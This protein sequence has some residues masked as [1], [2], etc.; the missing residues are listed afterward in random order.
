MNIREMIFILFS[1][2]RII[3]ETLANMYVLA[4]LTCYMIDGTDTIITT[5]GTNTY[6]DNKVDL[7]FTVFDSYG[8]LELDE[9]NKRIVNNSGRTRTFAFDGIS[10]ISLPSTPNMF[11]WYALF[12]NGSVKQDQTI[13]F[14]KLIGVDGAALLGVDS[15]VTLNDGDYVEI[16]CKTD[17]LD[18]SFTAAHTQIRFIEIPSLGVPV[19]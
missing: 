1:K 11:V 17:K 19:A 16:F 3:K 8:G 4:G 15:S 5:T 12:K 13:S 18:G 10:T 14:G 9:I 7:P 2:I 6:V